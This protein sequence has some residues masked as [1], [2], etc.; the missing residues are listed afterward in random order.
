[1]TVMSAAEFDSLL[2]RVDDKL[3]QM[4]E[5]T[6]H[7]FDKLE[8][9][10]HRLG[11]LGHSIMQVLAYVPKLIGK[12]F[13]WIGQLIVNPGVPWTLWNH[14]NDWSGA[15]V[16]GKVSALVGKAT[17]DEVRVDDFWQGRA[18]DA[19]K[20][21][22][23][24]QKEAL[25]KIVS[26]AQAVDDALTKMAIAI[27]ALWLALLTAILSAVVEY[28][29]E[30]AAAATGVGAPPAA[31]GAAATT[32]KVLALVTA[33]LDVFFVFIVANTL[34]VLKS[35]RHDLLDSSAFPDGHWPRSTT[36]F[37]DGSLSDG[38]PTDWHLRVS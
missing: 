18:A 30:G 10:A 2:N 21:T 27:G 25:A 13:E 3:R 36:D 15:P 17:L 31:A 22:L 26:A 29:A 28:I 7:L 5:V 38:D 4:R 37:S 11:P 24:R 33:A 23:P 34:P 9:W 20:N 12:V 32:A 35:L 1:M 14:G 16:A 8:T 6:E 19:Y